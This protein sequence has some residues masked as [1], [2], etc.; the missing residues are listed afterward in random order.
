MLGFRYAVLCALACAL[1]LPAMA[2]A[3]P[4]AIERALAQERYY[5]NQGAHDSTACALAQERYYSSLGRPARLS[6]PQSPPSDDGT[7]WVLIGLPVVAGAMAL[8]LRAMRR[9]RVA[10]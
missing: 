6:L 3:R 10:G 7:P 1:L 5:M 8:A 2:A 4:S 9:H